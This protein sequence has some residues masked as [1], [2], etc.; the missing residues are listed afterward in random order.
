[1]QDFDPDYELI[2]DEGRSAFKAEHLHESAGLGRFFKR[3]NDG[4]IAKGSVLI[5]E[6]LDRFS[7]ENPFK[8]VE[9]ISQLD[10]AQIE[11]HDVEK[12][13][14]I[15]RKHSNSLTFATM[16]AERSYEESCLK[17]TRIRKG[18]DKRRKKAKDEGQYMI[19]N[20]L[21]QQ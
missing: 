13:L 14:I 19:K 6:S 9:Y 18:W 2:I 7:R 21:T 12:R 1:M 8:C 5:V 4:D 20:D 3:V 16:I 17:S 15:S 11:L 10:R